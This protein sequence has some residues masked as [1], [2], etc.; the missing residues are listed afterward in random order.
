[1]IRKPLFLL[2][3]LLGVGAVLAVFARPLPA[4]SFDATLHDR[5]VVR[6]T[7]DDRDMVAELANWTEPWDVDYEQNVVIVEVDKAG[8]ERLETTGFVVEVD[9]RLTAEMH[10]P[11]TALP[12]QGGGI[13]GYEC[14]RTV[15]ET[16][17]T[18]IDLTTMYPDFATWIDVGDSWDKETP[19]GPAG[20]T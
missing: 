20:M 6:A 11:R 2:A 15:E 17:Q 16:Y 9:P 19:G 8:W 12:N 13:P 14:Y 18:A 7:F 5:W 1:M 3:L 10:Q 4:G